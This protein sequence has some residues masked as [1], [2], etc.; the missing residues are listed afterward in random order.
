MEYGLIS[1]LPPLL[2]I[3]LA[4]ILK[5]V[6]LALFLGILSSYIIIDANLFAAFN[7]TLNGFIGAF[8]SSSNVI[9][10]GCILTLGALTVLFEKTGGIEGFVNL[11]IKKK[12]IVKSPKGA[13]IFTFIIGCLVYTSGTLSTMVTGSVCRPINDSLRVSHE[14]AA[15]IV[16]TTSM[17]ICLLFPL[18]GWAG[19]ML[20][21][22]TSAGI[23][24]NE[25]TSVLIGSIPF[26]VYAIIVVLM[27]KSTV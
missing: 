10:M 25:A 1:V 21:C 17:P 4:L 9:V 15:Y 8:S 22:L 16:H 23:P 26:N 12:G 27:L 5:N 13:S 7:S 19:T 2:T 20:A 3:S 6:Y 18:S 14:K 11:V 24:E